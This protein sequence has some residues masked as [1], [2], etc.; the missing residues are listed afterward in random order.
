[1]LA[2]VIV[3]SLWGQTDSTPFVGLDWFYESPCGARR[4]LI[5]GVR[6]MIH[7]TASGVLSETTISR[8]GRHQVTTDHSDW[9]GSSVLSSD[10][11]DQ[12][13]LLEQRSIRQREPGTSTSCSYDGNGRT[14]TRTRYHNGKVY[15]VE[16]FAYQER[17]ISVRFRSDVTE[18]V[19]E[20]LLDS[21]G[22]VVRQARKDSAGEYQVYEHRYLDKNVRETCFLDLGRSCRINAV[23]S[24]GNAVSGG[25]LYDAA[26]NWT[27]R[28]A[29]LGG[30]PGRTEHREIAYW[31]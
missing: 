16:S 9:G 19:T 26:G 18:F 6:T 1:V 24:H 20:Y 11:D 30:R 13:R 12:G 4:D 15:T 22:R 28:K 5:G 7:Y 27:E 23:D 3:L 8:D 17:M 10:Y 21:L 29:D 31:R 2:L 25:Y 14:Q